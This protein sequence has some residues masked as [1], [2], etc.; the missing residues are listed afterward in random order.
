MRW[1][2]SR[3]AQ[4]SLRAK[5]EARVLFPEP[6]M[7]IKIRH[8]AGS[9]MQSLLQLTPLTSWLAPRARPGKRMGISSPGIFMEMVKR[10]TADLDPAC[11]KNTH[12]AQK[13]VKAKPVNI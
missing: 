8:K 2:V 12:L 9:G 5:A 7:P 13:Y 10:Q 6:G 4:A 3:Q 11:S 1:S